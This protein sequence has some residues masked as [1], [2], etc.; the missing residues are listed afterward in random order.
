MVQR[1]R[2]FLLI[3]F[4]LNLINGIYSTNFCFFKQDSD[5]PSKCSVRI[6]NVVKVYVQMTN[7]HVMIPI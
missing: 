6:I 2:K 3:L 1:L 7:K 4:I 5:V